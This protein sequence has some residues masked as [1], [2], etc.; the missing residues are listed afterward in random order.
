MGLLPDAQTNARGSFQV[1]FYPVG[2]KCA[3]SFSQLVSPSFSVYFH[4]LRMRQ[5]GGVGKQVRSMGH[6]FIIRI[7]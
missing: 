7:Y 6:E 4:P 1:K 2:R 3:H 5:A